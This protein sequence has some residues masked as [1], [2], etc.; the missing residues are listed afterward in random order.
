MKH[1]LYRTTLTAL[2]IATG[3][4]QIVS[5]EQLKIQVIDRQT[6]A[7]LS[8]ATVVL[9]GQTLQ[10]D[11]DGLANS[12]GTCDSLTISFVGYVSKTVAIP[13]VSGRVTVLLE[14]TELLL[15]DVLVTAQRSERSVDQTPRS[16]YR[17]DSRRIESSGA[18]T[19]IE[20]LRDLPGVASTDA[21]S[22]RVRPVVRGLYGSRLLLM[23][24]G[25]RLND[26]REVSDF[27]G[28]SLS[29]I[30]VQKIEQIEVVS[31]AGSSLYGSDAMGG[32]INVI[33]RPRSFSDQ[34]KPTARYS[35]RYS[36]SDAQANQQLSLGLS[37]N[38]WN[39]GADVARRATGRDFQPPDGW[40]TDLSSGV[41]RQSF[42]DSL[43]TRS[44]KQF[45]GRGLV[46][47]GAEALSYGG[48]IGFRSG[49]YARLELKGG[50]FEA[51]NIGYPGVPNDSTP[52]FFRYPYHERTN[53][54]LEFVHERPFAAMGQLKSKLYFQRVKKQFAT[55]FLGSLRIPTG[56][57]GPTIVPQVADNFTDV[58]K[59]GLNAQQQFMLG[60]SVKSMIGFDGYLEQISGRVR[61]VTLLDFSF[62]GPPDMTE[63]EERANVPTSDWKAAGLFARL[64]HPLSRFRFEYVLRGDYVSVE[65]KSTSGY[66][67]ESSNLLPTDDDTYQSLSGSL[68]ISRPISK[69]VSL[70]GSAATA[71]RI[72]NTVERFFYGDQEG[73]TIRPN[74]SLSPERSYSG[75]IGFKGVQPELSYSVVGFTSRYD[76][77]IQLRQNS[78]GFW[79][80]Q[81]A[82][83]A[84]IY[85][86]ET[87]VEGALQNGLFS[88]L[89]VSWQHG[90]SKIDN[91]Q[92]PLFVTPLSTS[93]S[94]GWRDRDRRSSF[95]M[96]ARWVDAQ[97]RIA[98]TTALED[99]ATK[100]FVMVNLSAGYRLWNSVQ[101]T[102]TVRNVFDKLYS[103]PYNARV[104]DNPIPE[105]GRSLV[106][107]I[108]SEL[109]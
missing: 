46:N 44:G 22:F 33:T 77:F 95:E 10:T 102:V 81:N 91:Q 105:P 97:T 7:A 17:A 48:S 109:F 2:L 11:K 36:G 87:F 70:F 84:T 57:G 63:T 52:F 90:D 34:L 98:T 93:L 20:S 79:Q 101:T 54:S 69:G 41:F 78:E 14:Q 88:S 21:G 28:V 37:S 64:E 73:R 55:D 9:C 86:F 5:A 65:T 107:S 74:P 106:V 49:E 29:L 104:P 89:A 24:D 100:S 18:Q 94:A 27:A 30:D 38:R 39:F 3:F 40:Q 72:P 76:R 53:G 66:L 23:V 32:V 51:T 35:A 31:G 12:D 99:A 82:E 26:Q 4:G 75:E 43:A 16:A 67:D 108:S 50:R 80:Y 103:E 68:S 42:Y 45:G 6:G 47:S 58:S 59:Y 71:Y 83:E 56:P 8:G 62:P 85:G 92:Q 60:S 25:E 96:T 61:E 13:S 15:D 1:N 19:A